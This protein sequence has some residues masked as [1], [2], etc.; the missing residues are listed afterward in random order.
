ML[1]MKHMKLQDAA[2]TAWH[3]ITCAYT[4]PYALTAYGQMLDTLGFCSHTHTQKSNFTVY[5]LMV[6]HWF[7]RVV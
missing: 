6:T 7:S 2:V 1:Q 5:L 4:H 3:F